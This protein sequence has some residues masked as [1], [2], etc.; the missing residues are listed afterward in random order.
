M[1]LRKP[2]D[3]RRQ[4]R[5]AGKGRIG[6]YRGAP[7]GGASGS[8]PALIQAGISLLGYDFR[9]TGARSALTNVFTSV[10]PGSTLVA[11][12]TRRATIGQQHLVDV[13][14]SVSLSNWDLSGA[15]FVLAASAS[16]TLTDCKSAPDLTQAAINIDVS[17]NNCT[18]ICDYCEFDGLKM[19]ATFPSCFARV[20][21]TTTGS[22]L[23][24]SHSRFHGMGGDALNGVAL[25]VDHCWF[26]DAAYGSGAHPDFQQ[27]TTGSNISFTYCLM[28]GTNAGQPDN[29]NNCIRMVAESGGTVDTMEVGNCIIVSNNASQ[30]P[31]ALG[32]RT[33]NTPPGTDGVAATNFNI[34]DNYVR[35][36][37]SDYVY[38]IYGPSGGAN[39]WINNKDLDSLSLI[40]APA[41]GTWLTS[42]YTP[43]FYFLGF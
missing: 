37:S 28:D 34:H 4:P 24:I 21:S 5:P 39:Y 14:G 42:S 15:S 12:A 8:I 27:L 26:Y 43:T 38:A 35:K 29:I 41:V 23:H 11:G 7:L 9:N 3:A 1:V 40:S 33:G 16:L 30:P 13:V 18:V 17:N 32:N 22:S 6:P 20:R 31:I 10:T 25:T 2:R 19:T 36:G